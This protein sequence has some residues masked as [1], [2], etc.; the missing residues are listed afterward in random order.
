MDATASL[1]LH[2]PNDSQQRL[3]L[4]S[5]MGHCG[6]D[7]SLSVFLYVKDHPLLPLDRFF[8]LFTS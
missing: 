7:V 8:A 5:Q 2:T 6:T 1:Q 4:L 3:L